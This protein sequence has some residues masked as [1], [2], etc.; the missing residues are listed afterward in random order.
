M[1]KTIISVTFISHSM[2]RLAK[3]YA[4]FIQCENLPVKLYMHLNC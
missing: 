2:F 1:A 3:V 4:V